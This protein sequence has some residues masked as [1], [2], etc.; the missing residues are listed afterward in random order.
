MDRSK[1]YL[2]K[3]II[4]AAILKN[5]ILKQKLLLKFFHQEF[6]K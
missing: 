4:P 6:Y 2:A 5:P 1:F 3:D